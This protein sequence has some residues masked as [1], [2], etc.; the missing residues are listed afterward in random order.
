MLLVLGTLLAGCAPTVQA[1]NPYVDSDLNCEELAFEI[2]RTTSL[3]AEAESNKGLSAQNVA[4]A[5]LFWPGIFANEASNSDAI[6]VADERLHYLYRYYDEKNCT[7][8]I[9]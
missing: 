5:F 8:V 7:T 9:R 2:S 4:W 1:Y 6:R 3:K